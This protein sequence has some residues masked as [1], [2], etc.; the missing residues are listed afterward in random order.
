[1]MQLKLITDIC[2]INS[3]C[4]LLTECYDLLGYQVKGACG[5]GGETQ[6][7]W[8]WPHWTVLFFLRRCLRICWH[9]LLILVVFMDSDMENPAVLWDQYSLLEKPRLKSKEQNF[10]EIMELP[11]VVMQNGKGR[12]QGME[13]PRIKVSVYWSKVT[14]TLQAFPIYSYKQ[15]NN[16]LNKLF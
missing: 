8:H 2:P 4:C 10:C 11:S 6:G 5:I 7:T 1:M 9:Y 15:D 14:A 12:K 3:L 16:S 13:E